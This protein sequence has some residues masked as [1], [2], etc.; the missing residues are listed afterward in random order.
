MLLVPH[1]PAN[2]RFDN[3]TAL[4]CQH[5]G[6]NFQ[7]FAE[8]CDNKHTLSNKGNPLILHTELLRS[9]AQLGACGY[10]HTSLTRSISTKE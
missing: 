6:I 10:L 2:L 5:P 9:C 8:Q 3:K 1:T 4:P 7:V